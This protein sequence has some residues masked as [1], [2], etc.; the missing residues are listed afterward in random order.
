[1]TRV[2]IIGGIGGLTA[3]SALSQASQ[4]RRRRASAGLSDPQSGIGNR[5]W[6]ACSRSEVISS[7]SVA[8]SS[9]VPMDTL[10]TR[11]RMT[12]LAELAEIVSSWLPR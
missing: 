9:S 10:V 1:M 8:A 5:R 11:S 2:A 4:G 6:G 7:D 3:A 12:S